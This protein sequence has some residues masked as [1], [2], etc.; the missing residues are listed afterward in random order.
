MKIWTLLLTMLL[1]ASCGRGNK[2]RHPAPD[3]YAGDTRTSLTGDECES[4]VN[5]DGS[6]WVKCIVTIC[7]Y[8][9]AGVWRTMRDEVSTIFQKYFD[10]PHDHRGECGNEDLES[11]R[12]SIEEAEGSVG[13][14]EIRTESEE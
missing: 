14:M 7:H 13:E 10:S 12:T 6:V 2:K 8:E 4:G 11:H 1:L 9:G 5:A 3:P